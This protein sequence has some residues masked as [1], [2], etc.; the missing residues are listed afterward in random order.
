MPRG[1]G[2]AKSA[3]VKR[4]RGKGSV[5]S[6]VGLRILGDASHSYQGYMRPEL[7]GSNLRESKYPKLSKSRGRAVMPVQPIYA[8][9]R[10]YFPIRRDGTAFKHMAHQFNNNKLRPDRIGMPRQITRSR[11]TAPTNVA[12]ESSYE[13]D[14]NRSKSMRRAR[15]ARTGKTIKERMAALERAA[16]GNKTKTKTNAVN[17]SR[18]TNSKGKAAAKRAFM[19]R[20][21][22]TVA[23]RKTKRRSK[24]KGKGSKRLV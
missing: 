16:A 19:S 15:E 3:K 11:V 5:K 18:I 10:E 1:R 20:F 21:G 8:N 14:A 9:N 24:G 4:G 13:Q 17:N 7:G 2:R 22:G 6:K 23:G 12:K